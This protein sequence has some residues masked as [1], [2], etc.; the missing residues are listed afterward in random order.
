MLFLSSYVMHWFITGICSFPKFI[1]NA[2]VSYRNLCCSY[3][4]HW[5]LKG[6]YAIP[7]FI[8]DALVFYR[9]VCCS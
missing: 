4:M 1:C 7:M 6:M 2:L 5:F 3:V 9:H 8:R